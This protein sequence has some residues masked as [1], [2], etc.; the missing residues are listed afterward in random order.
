M[1]EPAIG[2]RKSEIDNLLSRPDEQ[3]LREYKYRF[4]QSIVFGLPVVGL[5]FAAPLL[6]PTDFERWGSLL[7]ALLAGWVVYVNLGMLAEGMLLRR[8][9]SDLLVSSAS[10]L[11]YLFSL[12]TAMH[13][14]VLGRLWYRPVLF[15]A[16]VVVLAAWTGLQWWRRARAARRHACV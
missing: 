8:V 5:H 12:I 14:V 9:T 11:L 16:C 2:N 4:S 1:S 13:A 7:S 15:H 6:G 10:I 3:R